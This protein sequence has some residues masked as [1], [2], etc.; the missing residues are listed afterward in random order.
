MKLLL[1]ISFLGTNYCGYQIQPN[2]I[3]I[4]QRLNEATKAL[5]GYDCDIVGCSRT[6]SGVHAN[7]FCATVT[8][9]GHNEI[10][11][12]IPIKK[13]PYAISNYLPDDICVFD[14][15]EME[16]DFH[17]RYD[18]KYKEY[19]Y[20]I[21]NGPFNDPFYKDR[22]WH[23][24]KHID[25]A[26]LE[27]MKKAAGYFVGTYDFSSYMSS[28]TKVKDT[29]RTVYSADVTRDGNMI[30]FKVSANGFLYNMVRIFTG[31]LIA[32]AEEKISAD[33]IPKIT[34]NRDRKAAGI[35]VPAHGLF[36]NKVVY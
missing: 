27:N 3:T 19:V 30:E 2:G 13:I 25:D 23:Y 29:V 4:Q 26:A 21:W 35:T 18:V 20:R 8:Q 15:E 1:H 12:T 7:H 31:T 22:A 33:D 34:E 9:K 36:L 24:P 11:T 14:A 5:F 32:V 17:P 10:F 16:S 6:D 28:D